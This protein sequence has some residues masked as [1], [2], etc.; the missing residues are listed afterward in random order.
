MRIALAYVT[1]ERGFDLAVYSAMSIAISQRSCCD[2]H[3]FCYRF[4]PAQPEALARALALRGHGL[5]LHPISDD[6][7]EGHQTCGHV[8]TPSLLKITAVE[9]LIQVYDRVVY[10]DN[11]VLVF[12][13]LNVA[14][15]DFDGCP[16]AAVVDMDIS[17]TG[18]LRDAAWARP[19]ATSRDIS[20]YFNV[21]VMAFESSSWRGANYYDQ[22]AASL[23][24]HDIACRYKLSCTSIEQCALNEVFEDRWARLPARYNMQAGAKFTS[25]W[26][27][28]LVRHY[29]GPRKFLPL[30][31]FRNDARDVRLLNDIMRAAGLP[32][33]SPA[34]F[35]LP[36]RLNCLRHYASAASMRRFLSVL[37]V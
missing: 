9:V 6:A 29:C 2:V 24:R 25:A 14:A 27:T 32:S 28:A 34:L 33:R 12:D 26:K 15:I 19:G 8:T 35:E 5:A 30:S 16:V 13:D 31:W 3:I 37:E 10:L 21:G 4:N 1:D 11:D 20:H 23:H 7:V 22:Y 17:R 36:F 18:A